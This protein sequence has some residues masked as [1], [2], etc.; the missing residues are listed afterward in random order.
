M[1]FFIVCYLDNLKETKRADCLCITAKTAL[2]I[3]TK[4]IN[5]TFVLDQKLKEIKA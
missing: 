5:R 2:E 1:P 3:K 4:I